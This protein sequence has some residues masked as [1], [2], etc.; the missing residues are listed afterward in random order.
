MQNNTLSSKNNE[1]NYATH[2]FLLQGHTHHAAAVLMHAH[3]AFISALKSSAGSN[4]TKTNM[5]NPHVTIPPAKSCS[6]PVQQLLLSSLC[7]SRRQYQ[8]RQ[9]VEFILRPLHDLPC[10]QTVQVAAQLLALTSRNIT[11]AVL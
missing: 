1:C 6:P 7:V 9:M 5:R 11:T 8:Q 4:L 10:R 2:M 3:H